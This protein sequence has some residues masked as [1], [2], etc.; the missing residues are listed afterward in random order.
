MAPPC[1]D[2]DS[3]GQIAKQIRVKVNPEELHK[4]D[5]NNL[6]SGMGK[7]VFITQESEAPTSSNNNLYG[8]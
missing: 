2:Y 3:I 7:T 5:F 4:Y 6:L 8:L 1:P